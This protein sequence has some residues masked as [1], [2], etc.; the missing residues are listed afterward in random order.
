MLANACGPCIGQW[1]RKD[2]KKG[3]KN[4]IVTSFNRNFTSRN[5]GNPATHAFVASPDIVTAMAIAGS[6]S[7]N[8]ITD[9]LKDAS[10]NAF[11]FSPP[12]GSDLPQSGFDAGE[13]TFQKPPADGSKVQ[14]VVDPKSD[15][16]Q[17]LK[18]FA[19]WNGKD[20]KG[21]FHRAIVNRRLMRPVYRRPSAH[22]GSR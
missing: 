2:V 5:D 1:D 4:S 13:E 14:V 12:T 20:I 6:L 22:Q 3:E 11:K 7:F 21:Q 19:P 18:P 16:L 8:P 9:T 15:R 17:L 10:G